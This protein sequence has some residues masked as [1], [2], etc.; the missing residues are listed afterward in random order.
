MTHVDLLAITNLPGFKFIRHLLKG[1]ARTS[2]HGGVGDF[3]WLSG[4][5]PSCC[6]CID[7]VVVP[8]EVLETKLLKIAGWVLGRHC[9][10]CKSKML[11]LTWRKSQEHLKLRRLTEAGRSSRWGGPGTCSHSAPADI[12]PVSKWAHDSMS[13]QSPQEEQESHLKYNVSQVL[14]VCNYFFLEAQCETNKIKISVGR[15]FLCRPLVW[16]LWLKGRLRHL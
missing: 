4:Q 10:K 12:R 6:L 2:W 15:I 13:F 9:V 8:A 7:P 1:R 11:P 16:G 14:K 5:P 3:L